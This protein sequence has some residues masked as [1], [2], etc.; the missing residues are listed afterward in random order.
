MI[1]PRHLYTLHPTY[2]GPECAHCGKPAGVHA[3]PDVWLVDGKK[4]KPDGAP[5]VEAQR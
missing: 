5:I 2:T 1:D 3:E 4:Q